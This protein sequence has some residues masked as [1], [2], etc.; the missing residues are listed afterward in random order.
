MYTCVDGVSRLSV[1][2]VSLKGGSRERKG[3]KD[4]GE[5]RTG[6]GKREVVT[7]CPPPPLGRRKGNGANCFSQCF[8]LVIIYTREDNDRFLVMALQLH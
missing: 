1:S 2:S 4:T 3:Q 5:G 6:Y 7:T 8:S